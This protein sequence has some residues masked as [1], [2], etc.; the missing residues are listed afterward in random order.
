M[1][2]EFEDYVYE[3]AA[4]LSEQDGEE[5]V[6]SILDVE[7]F[8]EVYDKIKVKGFKQVCGL[9]GGYDLYPLDE[10]IRGIICGMGYEEYL[11][12]LPDRSYQDWKIQGY[13]LE[14]LTDNFNISNSSC[15]IQ[16]IRKEDALK[17]FRGEF[18]QEYLDAVPES[19][20]VKRLFEET[21][22]KMN[23]KWLGGYKGA[24][25]VLEKD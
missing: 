15:F 18:L 2:K 16:S 8:K 1:R 17:V 14:E 23:V 12:K 4:E 3:I 20:K 5:V 24:Y 6:V 13:S 25:L 19:E 21:L 7:D 22:A 10:M 9:W 11:W